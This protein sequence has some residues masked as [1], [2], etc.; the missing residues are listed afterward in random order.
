MKHKTYMAVCTLLLC[1]CLQLRVSAQP[2]TI[3]MTP[4]QQIPLERMRIECNPKFYGLIDTSK[5]YINLASGFRA[6][7]FY[8]GGLK[9]PRFITFSPE[10]V[11]HVSDYGGGDGKVYAMP[12]A[13]NDGVADTVF[14]VAQALINNHDVKFYKG[15]MYVTETMRVNRFRDLDH[16]GSY[17]KRD[18]FI[19]GIANGGHSTRTIVFDSINQKLYLSTGS[20]C[21][22]CRDVNRADIKQYNEDGTG[23]HVHASGIRNAVGMTLHPYTN[24]LWADNNG[25]DNLGDTTPPEWVDL[26][27]ENGFYGWPFAYA[28][29]VWN[30]FNTGPSEY[31]ALRP[32]TASDSAKVAGMIEP[33]ALVHAHMAP[34]ALQFLNSSFPPAYQN[35]MLMAVH[36][37][38]NTNPGKFTGYKVQYLDLSSPTDTSVNYVTDFITGFLTDSVADTYWGRPCGLA[39]DLR[40]RIYMSSDEGNKFIL[41]IYP[42][43]PPGMGEKKM[44]DGFSSYPNPFKEEI[45]FDFTLSQHADVSLAVYDMQGRMAMNI[46]HTRMKSG[47]NEMVLNT[48]S[49]NAGIYFYQLKAGDESVTGKI[50]K[51]TE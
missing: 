5:L 18:T 4:V 39:V 40:G 49:L 35:G 13:N 1:L 34:M 46:P 51:T 50:V 17:D 12:D 25:S 48:A 43:I 22:V 45:H 8:T 36:G 26:V 10:G 16:N 33:A 38:W 15:A 19:S 44:L 24:R 31:Q 9:R 20:S 42:L 21:N 28:N 7:L 2:G 6:R 3:H 11:L 23:G 37:S 47:T 27:R 30:P 32:I 41:M 29:Q 14:V